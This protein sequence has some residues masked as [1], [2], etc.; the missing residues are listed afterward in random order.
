MGTKAWALGTVHFRFFRSLVC[1]SHS[2]S[3]PCRTVVPGRL[4]RHKSWCVDSLWYTQS[5]RPGM[6]G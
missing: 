4:M 6:W 2:S 1:H 5:P 3:T